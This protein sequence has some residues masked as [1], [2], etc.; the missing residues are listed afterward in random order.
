LKRIQSYL[1]L[2]ELSLDMVINK[3]SPAKDSPYAIKIENKNFSWGLKT[4]D[5]DEIF[6]KIYDEMKGEVEEK[7]RSKEEQEEHEK[8]LIK[9]AE[10]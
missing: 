5:I 7:V 9:K 8:N 2:E 6:E 10:E 1:D 3:A 4:K